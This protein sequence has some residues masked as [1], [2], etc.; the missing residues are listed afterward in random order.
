MTNKS[1]TAP[2]FNVFQRERANSIQHWHIKCGT[3]A[4]MSSSTLQHGK[5]MK[6]SRETD[7][8]VKQNMN[9]ERIIVRAYLPTGSLL[10]EKMDEVPPLTQIIHQLPSEGTRMKLN[11]EQEEI[12]FS[13]HGHTHY[14]TVKKA[15]KSIDGNQYIGAA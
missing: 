1:F 10:P 14:Y 7:E 8:R 15:E 5:C 13:K 9:M 6:K 3:H 2:R 12:N 4:R 11:R